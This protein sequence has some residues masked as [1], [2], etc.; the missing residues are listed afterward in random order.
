MILI[1]HMLL[2]HGGRVVPTDFAERLLFWIDAGFPELG[3]PGQV[4]CAELYAAGDFAGMGLGSTVGRVCHRPNFRADPH[5]AAK[6][7]WEAT[8]R[9]LAANGAGMHFYHRPW[10]IPCRQ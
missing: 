3:R 8:G 10:L 1:L 5:A 9:E 6:E 7:V 4:A 2:R